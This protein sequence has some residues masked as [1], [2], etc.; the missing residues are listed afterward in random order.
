M[1]PFAYSGQAKNWTRR[2][3]WC[4]IAFFGAVSAFVLATILFG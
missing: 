1:G 2:D 4:A 3:T